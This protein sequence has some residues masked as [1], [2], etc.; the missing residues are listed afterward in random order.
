MKTCILFSISSTPYLDGNMCT[1]LIVERGSSVVECRTCNREN[2]GS[3]PPFASI[4]KLGHFRS[5]H[6]FSSFSCI[7][8]IDSGGN[9]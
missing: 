3:N 5:L 8:V 6:D 1:F 7:N 9:T 2:P 4:S